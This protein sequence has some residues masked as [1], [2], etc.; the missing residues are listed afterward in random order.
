MGDVCSFQL[1]NVISL[2][3]FGTT[4]QSAKTV[5]VTC[6]VLQNMLV[7]KLQE[8]TLL[9]KSLDLPFISFYF[10][11]KWEMGA[12]IYSIY[13]ANTAVKSQYLVSRHSVNS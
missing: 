12:A 5:N 3:R 6:L 11:K 13:K 2:W 4:G 8:I 7:E 10:A 1:V 9:C